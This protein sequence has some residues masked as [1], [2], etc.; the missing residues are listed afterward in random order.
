MHL[1]NHV[2]VSERT[3]VFFA[4]SGRLWSGSGVSGR[5]AAPTSDLQSQLTLRHEARVYPD[6]QRGLYCVST[7]L[8]V[9]FSAFHSSAPLRAP[10]EP[11]S[12][13]RAAVRSFNLTDGVL[14]TAVGWYDTHWVTASSTV[15]RF[16]LGAS[17]L[18][19]RSRTP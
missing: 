14:L 2:P 19:P 7:C 16:I 11:D 9:A 1:P 17:Q 12:Y 15:H 6:N 10:S 4:S 3:W 13:G 8:R 18:R 5:K